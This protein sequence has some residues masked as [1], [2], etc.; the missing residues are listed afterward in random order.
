MPCIF[1]LKKEKRICNRFSFFRMFFSLFRIFVLTL[2]DKIR[3]LP[4]R[5]PIRPASLH[6]DQFLPHLAVFLPYPADPLV[7]VHN[8][9]YADHADTMNFPPHAALN[10]F[11]LPFRLLRPCLQNFSLPLFHMLRFSLP[12]FHM[13]RFSLPLFHILR[14]SLP[15]FRTL[16]STRLTAP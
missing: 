5:H 10:A 3:V 6:Q 7:F 4:V 14:F 8:L 16:H 1:I 15:L 13:L 11:P 9:P 2:F 12:L